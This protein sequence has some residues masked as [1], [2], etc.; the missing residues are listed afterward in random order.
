MK[1]ENQKMASIKERQYQQS[2]TG[3]HSNNNDDDDG[4]S[5]CG[6]WDLP[7]I[8]TKP[9]DAPCD[10]KPKPPK[11][12]EP[13]PKPPHSRGK[14]QDCCKQILDILRQM[15]GGSD[16][17]VKKP[18]QSPKVKSA[19]LCCK[20]PIKDAI[21]PILL[22]FLRR[23]LNQTPP[24]NDFEKAI[25]VFLAGLPPEKIEALKIGLDA[26]D[27]LAPSI[28]DCAFET[29]FDTCGNDS[30]LDPKFLFK[31]WLNEAL[32]L[33]RASLFDKEGGELGI[34][35]VRL[36]ERSFPVDADSHGPNNQTAPWPWI[37]QVN[38][39]ADGRDWYKNTEVTTPGNLPLSIFR[40][41]NHEFSKACVQIPD[42][43]DASKF[44]FNCDYKR[45]APSRF[46]ASCEEIGKGP[47]FRYNFPD[48]SGTVCLKVPKTFPGQG[49]ALSGLNFISPNSKARLRRVGGG[50]QDL[51]LDCGVMG[52]TQTPL[53]R[54]GKVVA[55]CEVRD[56]ITFTIPEKVK[57]GVND[58]PVPPG[59]Y[60]LDVIV[61][62]DTNYA[63]KPGPAPAEFVSND[64]WLDVVPS[65]DQQ[66]RVWTDEAFCIEET[67]GLGSDEPWFQA[68]SV[69]FVPT[70]TSL[71]TMLPHQQ[72]T[73]MRTAGVDSGERIA[74]AAPDLFHGKFVIGEVFAL[75]VYGLEVDSNDA[76]EKQIK[77]F[78]DA[79]VLYWENVLTQL[80]VTSDVS[81][82]TGLISKGVATGTSLAIGAGILAGIAV[83]GLFYAAWAPADPIGYDVMTFDSFSLFDLTNP[84][85]PL[86]ATFSKSFG[87]LS[88]EVNPKDKLVQPGGTQARY[89]EDHIYRSSD[90]DSTYKLAYR[91]ERI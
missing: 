5:P 12:L 55:S 65:P 13:C 43:G 47:Q 69:R 87:E 66:Y 86:P 32:H 21:V 41:D 81:L 74:F 73:I 11:Q 15:P 53:M 1:A 61:P 25:Q 33:G 38:P 42:P 71:I 46:V 34:G 63:P 49:V 82:V 30:L 36:W 2:P 52:D 27:K 59:R 75:S 78:G 58:V 14:D 3:S 17:Q 22:L 54:D 28:R 72:I 70:G 80:A 26:Y 88:L 19:N 6:I 90:E 79:Y 91:V 64:V 7:S 24:A 85:A 51:V 39:G 31:V 9:S 8:D 40:F 56:I 16:I 45:P 67:D 50:F 83:I 18:K 77:N 10:C 23:F 37:C 68:Y 84:G 60:V 62:N 20:L 44:R 57:I 89:S 76:A 4:N 48:P 29:R 35:Q